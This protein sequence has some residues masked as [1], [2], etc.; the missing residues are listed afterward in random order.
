MAQD[1]PPADPPRVYTIPAEVRPEQTFQIAIEAWVIGGA[2]GPWDVGIDRATRIIQI[3]FDYFCGWICPGPSSPAM[4]TFYLNIPGLPQGEY[5]IHLNGGASVD[6][7]LRIAAPTPVSVPVLDLSTI[8]ALV[9]LILAIALL[10]LH[11]IFN[12][13]AS[14]HG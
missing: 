11:I 5:I 13:K 8:S 9:A 1:Y 7:P 14:H 12:G 2:V 10:H 3:P 4:H 6:V